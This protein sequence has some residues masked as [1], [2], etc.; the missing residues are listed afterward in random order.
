LIQPNNLRSKK[1]KLAP[2]YE[3][4]DELSD[5]SSSVRYVT[6]NGQKAHQFQQ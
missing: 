2:V 1:R 4:L 6:I 3:Y 5:N